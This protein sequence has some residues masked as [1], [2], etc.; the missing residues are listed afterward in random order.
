ME[1]ATRFDPVIG[2]FNKYIHNVRRDDDGFRS[3]PIKKRHWDEDPFRELVELFLREGL[4]RRDGNRLCY[5]DGE[6]NRF[7]HGG[8]F[9]YHVFGIVDDLRRDWRRNRRKP[10][11]QDLAAGLNIEGPSGVPNEIDVALS[12][13]QPTLP[14]GVQNRLL[15]QKPGQGGQGQY[16][17]L[18]DRLAEGTWGRPGAKAAVISYRG[19]PAHDLDRAAQMDIAAPNGQR[20][21]GDLRGFFE[22]WIDG[23]RLGL[24]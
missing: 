9:E 11:I 7:L 19:L 6:V 24:D 2:L 10:L 5:G 1:G 17:A 16:R 13:Q 18:Q 20:D 23:E 15:R 4:V 8:W 3:Q 21:M 14:G 12:G 22:R